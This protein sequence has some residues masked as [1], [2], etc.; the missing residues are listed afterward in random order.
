MKTKTIINSFM[1]LALCSVFFALPSM[2][3]D[4]SSVIT[5]DQA[6]LEESS[7]ENIDEKDEKGLT[8]LMRA[9]MHGDKVKVD[10]L[11]AKKAN[12]NI[13]SDDGY[14]ALMYAVK[15][16]YTD[17]VETLAP[18]EGINLNIKS[19]D[20]DTALIMAINRADEDM[21][22]ILADKGANLDAKN[23]QGETP[24]L[25]AFN[26][27]D[28]K[29]FGILVD[30][31]ANVNIKYENGNQMKGILSYLQKQYG[32]DLHNNNIVNINII[33]HFP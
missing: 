32:E 25:I 23:N 30:K 6:T 17:I 21:V 31:G 5:E 19:D 33:I 10:E 9:S 2:A 14:T 4:A 18:T 22:T 11:I 15:S 12:L 8:A 1:A 20:G 26:N 16:G 28:T 13:K 3:Q 7:Q 24:L 29:I 27:R